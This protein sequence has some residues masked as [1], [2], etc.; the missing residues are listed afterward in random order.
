SAAIENSKV[1]R[2][3]YT[4]TTTS[5]P[6]VDQGALKFKRAE[7]GVIFFIYVFYANCKNARLFAP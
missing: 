1:H 6:V 3:S 2:P 4:G 5:G 7:F